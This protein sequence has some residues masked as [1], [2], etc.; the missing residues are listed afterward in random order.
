M[1]RLLLTLAAVA[2]MLSVPASRAPAAGPAAQDV[3][4]IERGLDRAVASGKLTAGQAASYLDIAA[5]ARAE[6]KRIPPLRAQNLAFVLHEVAAQAGVYTPP[7]ALALF[8]MLAFNTSYF[9]THVLPRS[10]VDVTDEQGIV[11]RYFTN[12]GFQFHPLAE[13]GALTQ[14]VAAANDDPSKAA[15]ADALAQALLA[16]AVPTE[17]GLVWEYYFPFDGGRA[18]WTSGMAQAVFAQGFAQAGALL[19]DARLASAA[20]KAF[21]AIRRPLLRQLESGPWIRLYSFSGMVVLNA[22]LQTILSLASFARQSGDQQA[23]SLASALTA[24]AK[25]LLPR[26]DSGFWSYYSLARDESQ[27]DYQTYVI[28]LLRQLAA[29][30]GDPIW[31][32]YAD[33]FEGYLRQPPKLTADP[34]PPPTVYPVPADGY[35]DSVSFAFWLSKL[36]TVTLSAGGDKLT[37]VLAHGYHVLTW[38]PGPLPPGI[39]HPQLS[40]RDLA[41]NVTTVPTPAVEIAWDTTPPQLTA[42]RDGAWVRWSAEDPGTPWLRVRVA[43]R[44]GSTLRLIAL[45]KRPL[46]GLARVELPPGHWQVTLIG[47]NSAGK[48]ASVQL[49][50]T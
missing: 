14:A 44:R 11:Y 7:R 3:K 49:G 25:A 48:R 2:A 45:G 38:S 29:Q 23:V 43:L 18:P 28:T 30:T 6:L 39:Y 27:L 1:R 4:R 21:A 32:D 33:R 37:A 34:K 20:A 13:A 46:T 47:I 8:S 12:E 35:R 16:R 10:R 36:S 50:T 15:A 22:Q 5:R 41:G 9:G 26:F 24:S 19:G 42:I 17:A 40:A 31:S